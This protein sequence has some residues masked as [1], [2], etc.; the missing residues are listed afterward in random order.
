MDFDSGANDFAGEVWASQ[1][2][3]HTQRCKVNGKGRKENLVIPFWAFLRGFS[4]TFAVPFASFSVKAF[5]FTS[6]LTAY[7]T[8]NVTTVPIATY[9]VHGTF[10]SSQR[11]NS[12]TNPNSIP[13]IAPAWWARRVSTPSRKTPS[14]DP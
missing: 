13:T 11:Y 4:A 12:V 10:V 8:P 14:R 6:K 1:E 2:Q 7:P 5:S 3:K 9:Q